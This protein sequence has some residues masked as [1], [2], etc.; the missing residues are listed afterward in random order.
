MPAFDKAIKTGAAA[1][2]ELEPFTYYMEDLLPELS[3]FGILSK[4][5]AGIS[6]KM[7]WMYSGAGIAGWHAENSFMP[8][9]NWSP[10]IV[11]SGL[12]K[13]GDGGLAKAVVEFVK[14][15]SYKRWYFLDST[16]VTRIARVS[17][18]F[19]KALG[20]SELGIDT[21]ISRSALID[22]GMLSAK[23]FYSVVQR[24]G[25]LVFGDKPHMVM[26]INLFQL[27]WNAAPACLIESIVAKDF[28]IASIRRERLFQVGL[29]PH[30]A[31]RA[32]R[33]R[34][35]VALRII[36]S[37]LIAPP[38]RGNAT[39]VVWGR[40]PTPW[41]RHARRVGA[42][43]HHA[44]RG[45]GRRVHAR[46]YLRQRDRAPHHAGHLRAGVRVPGRH[47]ARHRYDGGAGGSGAR[48]HQGEPGGGGLRGGVRRDG[49]HGLRERRHPVQ[50]ERAP[51][52]RVRRALYRVCLCAL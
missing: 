2:T 31:L 12:E 42:P 22:P 6:R 20:M 30:T 24:P 19:G 48:G 7:P 21:L 35:I 25:D 27:A 18:G 10:E 8:F 40:N 52:Q 32:Q 49:D 13:L 29:R 50:C 26:G 15:Y 47:G 38:P 43:P 45:R 51:V 16:E 11:F 46:V 9:Y 39:R 23:S 34:G 41:Q 28:E 14:E 33:T 1:L 17:E 5:M 3:E 36:C 4:V 44:G 37:A